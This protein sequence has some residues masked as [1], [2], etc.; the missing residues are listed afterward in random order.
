VT[1]R[2]EADEEH[3]APSQDAG[4]PARRDDEASKKDT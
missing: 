2:L 4:E 3:N 1:I